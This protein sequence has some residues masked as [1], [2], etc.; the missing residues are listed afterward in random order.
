MSIPE[1]QAEA[2]KAAV[3]QL[4]AAYDR[5][6]EH[7]QELVGRGCYALAQEAHEIAVRVLRAYRAE[8]DDPKPVQ[9]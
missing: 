5:H 3:R 4:A 7:E 6:A 9:W 2:R 8:Q 1:L